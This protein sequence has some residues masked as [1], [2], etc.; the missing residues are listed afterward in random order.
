[1]YSFSH[2]AM[3]S[4]KRRFCCRHKEECRLKGG[5]KSALFHRFVSAGGQECSLRKDYWTDQC[6][7]NSL[8]DLNRLK[9][10]TVRRLR[11]EGLMPGCE[12]TCIE[13]D[14]G[15]SFILLCSDICPDYAGAEKAGIAWV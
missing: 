1:M 15:V 6:T 8:H 3:C 5:E 9:W 4:S 12:S 11:S 2:Q 7:Q 14:K 10:I 13:Q